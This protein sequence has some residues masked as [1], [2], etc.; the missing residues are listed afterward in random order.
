M[1]RFCY[2]NH[3]GLWALDQTW[4]EEKIGTIHSGTAEIIP[5][6]LRE[7]AARRPVEELFEIDQ[8]VAVIP[9]RGPL[10]KG[11][12][13][14]GGTSTV[15]ARRA[16]RLATESKEVAAILISIDSPGGHVAGTQELA[17]EVRRAGAV[18]P[19]HA[20]I[21][22]LGASAAM[23][24]ASQAQRISANRT[25][26]I[27]SIGVLSIIE[28]TTKLF[29]EK[30]IEVHVLTTGKL[31]GIG[32]PGVPVTPAHL[33]HIQERIDD[34]F[35]HF[36]GAIGAGRGLTGKRLAAV[37][38]ARIVIAQKAL[39]LGLL[40]GIGS[41]EDAVAVLVAGL[42]AS[43]AE[44][45]KGTKAAAAAGPVCQFDVAAARTRFPHRPGIQFECL[46]CGIPVTSSEG[47]EEVKVEGF[48]GYRC[49]ACSK[50]PAPVY[51]DGPDA[52]QLRRRLVMAR[53]EAAGE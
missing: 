10:M 29:E 28:D 16:I 7:R 43:R 31:K 32:A 6:E 40:D 9:L 27:G 20:H 33:E 21:E 47:G 34:V 50:I 15:M 46:D 48:V 1:S 25:A 22:D 4:L 12:S 2:T 51:Q 38:D 5:I 24:I 53:L 14:F 3:L 13:K 45:E 39:A 36:I 30:G 44:A 18:K 23:W 35:E 37:A 19:V 49:A 11:F 17:D 52:D 42:E 26:N 41:E 8:G